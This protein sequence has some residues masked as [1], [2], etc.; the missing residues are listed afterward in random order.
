NTAE[1][2]QQAGATVVSHPQSLGNGAAIKTGARK[3]GG[4]ILVMLDADGQHDPDD[5]P[6][7]LEQLEAGY[8]MAVGARF[9]KYEQQSFRRMHVFGNNLVRGLI[10]RIF[11]TQLTDILS[12]Y[13][14]FNRRVARAIPIVST[15]FEVETELTMHMLYYNLKIVEVPAAYRARREGSESK[16]NTV[17]DG[18]RVLWKIFS[19]VRAYKPLTFF[20]GMG[21]LLFLLGAVSGIA[22]VY[23][24]IVY[25]YVYHVPLAILATG[26]MLLSF[27]SVFL[28]LSLH[29]INWRLKELHNVLVRPRR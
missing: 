27:G 19:L 25:Q 11:H 29:A 23:D 24:Y 18:C 9:G 16:L 8:D 14:A 21:I 28:G 26:L 6:R 15:G 2:A 12:G 4:E 20:G 13:R 3:A 22:P 1:T 10:N 17:G 7:L 5:I